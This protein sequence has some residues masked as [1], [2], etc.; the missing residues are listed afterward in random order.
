[1]VDPSAASEHRHRRFHRVK[2]YLA[3]VLL[4]VLLLG[5]GVLL[6]L[7]TRPGREYAISQ[8]TRLLQQQN[9]EFA[10]DEL[11]YNLLDLR[12]SLRNLRLK[13]HEAPDLPPFATI[14]RVTVDLSLRALLRRR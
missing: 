9:M 11:R 7:H 10:T 4:A 2:K 8:V 12:L 13:S 3:I 6:L 1:M 5:A 14:D